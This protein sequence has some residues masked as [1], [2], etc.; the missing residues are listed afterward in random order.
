VPG[1]KVAGDLIVLCGENELHYEVYSLKDGL[2]RRLTVTDTG[3]ASFSV[4]G[5]ALALQIESGDDFRQ[6][7]DL[8]GE[9]LGWGEM[10]AVRDDHTV[11]TVRRDVRDGHWDQVY[12]GRRRVAEFWS[13]WDLRYRGRQLY[14]L[15]E[16][17]GR[18]WLVSDVGTRHQRR[19]ALQ[20]T[21]PGRFAVA[22][23]GRVAY[24]NGRG[25][26][27]L[28]LRFVDGPTY[29]IPRFPLD[30][31]R[32]GKRLLVGGPNGLGLL[33]PPTGKVEEIGKLACGSVVQAAWR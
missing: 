29:A 7:T 22:P 26:S 8:N 6:H 3:V 1:P 33:D 18:L 28:R 15:T 16:E 21:R 20:M 5:G 14:A 4:R 9:D 13:V 32:D 31:T 27:K 30:W 12:V 24:T 19:T 25:L 10:P 2:L 11:A 17:H 23:D